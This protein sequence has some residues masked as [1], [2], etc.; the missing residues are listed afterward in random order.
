MKLLE[1]LSEFG[2]ASLNVV[3][4]RPNGRQTAEAYGWNGEFY[5]ILSPYPANG[6]EEQGLETWN[7][8]FAVIAT[9]LGLAGCAPHEWAHQGDAGE[10]KRD[11]FDAGTRLTSQMLPVHAS[12]RPQEA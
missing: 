8:D 9:I 3:G 1:L 5:W 6:P 7:E 10:F 4:M 11:A 12:I 2:S